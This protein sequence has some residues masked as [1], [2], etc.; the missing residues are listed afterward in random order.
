MK[1]MFLIIAL[2]VLVLPAMSNAASPINNLE[3]VAIPVRSDGT[4]LP[5]EEI[6]AIILE[7]CLSRNWMPQPEA[8][9]TIV[10]TIDVRGKHSATV[11]IP[12]SLDRYSIL[13]VSSEN[14]DYNPRRESIHRNYNGWVVKLSQTIDFRLRTAARTVPSASG[15]ANGDG[16]GGD[17]ST[18]LLKLLVERDKG[19]LTP[20]EYD[21]EKKKILDRNQP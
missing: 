1:R 14:L 7:S 21:A 16:M 5:I 9:G 10:A 19:L 20:E 4:Q 18:E 11:R 2:A 6:Q 3:E 8:D 15:A 12:F 17:V 13:Y